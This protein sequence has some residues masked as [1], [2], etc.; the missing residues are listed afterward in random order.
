MVKV[1]FFEFINRDVFSEVVKY[2]SKVEGLNSQQVFLDNMLIFLTICSSW[3]YRQL[4]SRSTTDDITDILRGCNGQNWYQ[5]WAQTLHSTQ[6]QLFFLTQSHRLDPVRSPKLKRHAPALRALYTWS[7]S[8]IIS[9]A[10]CLPGHQISQKEDWRHAPRQS[11]RLFSTQQATIH[12]RTVCDE[13]NEGKFEVYLSISFASFHGKICSGCC[14]SLQSRALSP[15]TQSWCTASG[16]HVK[17][18]DSIQ[19]QRCR[20][21][22]CTERNAIRSL[23]ARSQWIN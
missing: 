6:S 22:L 2:P 7:I 10:S 12:Y 11:H 4:R 9:T 15:L 20:L 17:G 23:S 8:S 21:N 14:C 5:S 13:P 19:S 1:T 3:A 18:G 16:H